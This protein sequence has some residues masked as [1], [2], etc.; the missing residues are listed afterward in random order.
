MQGLNTTPVHGHT[1]LFGVYGMLGLGLMLFCVR[2]LMPG[3]EW[4][5]GALKFSFWAINIG[6]LLMVTVSLLPVGLMQTWAAVNQG[7]WYA[8]SA[9]FLQTPT[10]QT[11]RWL[12]VP[13]DTLFALGVLAMGWFKLGLLTGHSF[14]PDG[15][16]V[17]AGQPTPA[18]RKTVAAS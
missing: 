8:R 7:T 18:V 6:L 14:K 10:M 17:L 2:G 13:G 1:A 11:L 16:T 4:K 3:R 9:E 5:T 15:S 12:R